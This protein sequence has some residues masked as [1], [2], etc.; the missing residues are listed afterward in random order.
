MTQVRED[1]RR[2]G[3]KRRQS[4]TGQQG[5]KGD[6]GPQGVKGDKGDTGST[7]PRGLKGNKGVTGPQGPK[8]DKGDQGPSGGGLSNTGFT[9]QGAINM[10]SNKIV[11]LP[12]PQRDNE[13]VTKGYAD[14]NYKRLTDGGSVT[15]DTSVKI[16]K[17]T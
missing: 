16:W 12:N 13:P 11:N 1:Q 8:G 9:M 10:N 4:D 14:T 15:G 17:L 7:G 2:S 3:S 6:Q 5:S